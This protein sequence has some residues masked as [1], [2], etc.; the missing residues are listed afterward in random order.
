MKEPAP[1]LRIE[2]RWPVILA[3][4]A[5]LFLL[6]RL[7]RPIA[8]LPFW[9][10]CAAA[11]VVIVP[12]AAVGLI[13][14]KARWLRIERIVTLLFFV[15]VVA[16]IIVNLASLIREMVHRSAG[17]DGLQLLS[18]SIAVW[19]VNILVFSI[20]NW[21][22]DRGGPEDRVNNAGKKPDW[23]FPQEGAPAED[24]PPG[25]K[26][27]FVDYL[28]LGFTTATAFSPTDTLPL[29]SRAKMLMMLQSSISLATIVV[30]AAR[31]INILGN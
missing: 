7:P 26:P 17:I 29:T 9:I 3:I 12:M 8:M 4:L 1:V 16:G 20:L 30:V 27:T 6:T 5:V 28:F 13:A 21:Q 11:I 23:V 10:P 31:A 25:W 18:S 2:A 24:V 14:A 22:M 19:V 15:V